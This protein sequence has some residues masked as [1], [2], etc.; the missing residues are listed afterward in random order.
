MATAYAEALF[1]TENSVERTFLEGRL[2]ATDA[3]RAGRET[4]SVR[5]SP[6]SPECATSQTSIP[7]RR[8]TMS[9]TS[10]PSA[11]RTASLSGTM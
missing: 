6:L 1:L 3:I 9:P 10:T 5:W 11:R 7:S 4:R 2:H 8:V